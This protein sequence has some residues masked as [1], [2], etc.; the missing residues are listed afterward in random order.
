MS[1]RMIARLD[2]WRHMI[3]FWW[4]LT[5]DALVGVVI[6]IGV[7][8]WTFSMWLGYSVL[9]IAVLIDTVEFMVKRPRSAG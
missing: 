7:K 4:W 2:T 9:G 8:P 5:Y 6:A 1:E 3:P